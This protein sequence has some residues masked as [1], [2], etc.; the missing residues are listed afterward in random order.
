MSHDTSLDDGFHDTSLDDGFHDTS[1]DDGFHDTS[2]DDGFHDTSLDDG[3]HDTSLDDGFT[4]LAE[5]NA[6]SIQKIVSF[7]NNSS[8]TNS[9]LSYSTSGDKTQSCDFFFSS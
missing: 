3:F 2:L 6:V 1:L 9:R 7:I 8:I 4:I 5:F